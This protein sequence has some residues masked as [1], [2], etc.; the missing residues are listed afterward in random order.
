[1][2]TWFATTFFTFISWLYSATLERDW[3]QL[4]G[5]EGVL[6]EKEAGTGG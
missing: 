3:Q 6:E 5:T 1:M 4:K 2:Q